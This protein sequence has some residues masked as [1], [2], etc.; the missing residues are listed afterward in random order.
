MEIDRDCGYYTQDD[1]I[2]DNFVVSR[3]NS[4][5]LKCC[6]CQKLKTSENFIFNGNN[7]CS[8]CRTEYRQRYLTT[9]KGRLLTLIQTA[10]RNAIKRGR[11]QSRN[12]QSH[13]FSLTLEQVTTLFEQQNCLCAVT[14]IPVSLEP[15]LNRTVSLDRIDDARGYHV[16]NCRLVCHAVNAPRKFESQ[17]ILAFPLVMKSRVAHEAAAVARAR[18]SFQRKL[19]QL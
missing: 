6:A 4:L 9:Q 17:E 10:R 14:K 13:E 7:Y 19:T 18:L 2:I 12:D 8:V 11:L 15:H 16:D 1:E 3:H 5:V